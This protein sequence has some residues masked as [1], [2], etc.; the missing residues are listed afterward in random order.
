MNPSTKIDLTAY[1]EE[2]ERTVAIYNLKQSKAANRKTLILIKI[3]PKELVV[4]LDSQIA[5]AAPAKALRTFSQ[6]IVEEFPD[7][8]SQL[9]YHNHIFRSFPVLDTPQIEPP[10]IDSVAVEISDQKVLETMVRLCM[11]PLEDRTVKEKHV[12][13]KIK[14]LIY[15]AGLL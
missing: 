15:Q 5:L 2:L 9:L 8:A 11:K 3:T 14:Y 1:Q 6:I 13:S 4:A 10:A 7:L 12:L